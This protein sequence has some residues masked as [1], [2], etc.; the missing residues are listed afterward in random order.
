MDD[1]NTPILTCR[2]CDTE[3]FRKRKGGRAPTRCDACR[4]AFYREYYKQYDQGRGHVPHG[5]TVTLACRTCDAGT[6][7]WV[8]RQG[9]KPSMCDDCKAAA[10][11]A[12]KRR[13]SAARTAKLPQYDLS[14][15][16]V[17]CSA[18]FYRKSMRGAT[19]TRCPECRA[20]AIRAYMAVYS[21]S[22][23]AALIEVRRHTYEQ[24]GRWS[25]C[26]KCG[27][28]LSCPRMG[29]AREWCDRCRPAHIKTRR[30]LWRQKN[31]EAWRAIIARMNAKRRAAATSIEAEAFDPFT[32]F[33]RD[34]WVCQICLRRISKRLQWPDPMSVSLDHVVP[35]SEGGAHTRANTR[36]AHLRCNVARSNRG[37]GEQLAL[38]G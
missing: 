12:K 37:G 19:P 35:V 14:R 27:T 24:N 26:K 34:R 13:D 33:E 2:D 7:D 22:L 1:G 38:I 36:A 17:D 8:S 21:A 30:L 6:I 31:P 11:Q 9:R 4:D 20:K 32:V 10:Y 3:I 15:T 16:C 23:T 18:A 25:P 29:K 5:E 28:P